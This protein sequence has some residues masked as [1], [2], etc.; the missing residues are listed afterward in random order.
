MAIMMQLTADMLPTRERTYLRYSAWRLA[1]ALTQILANLGASFYMDGESLSPGWNY[2]Y[3]AEAAK[4]RG[5]EILRNADFS[6]GFQNWELW[7][8]APAK[9]KAAL[10]ADVPPE[11]AGERSV[12]IDVTKPS[13]TAWHVAFWQVGLR[14]KAGVTYTWSAWMKASK[15]SSVTAAIEKNHPPF[16]TAG[17]FEQVNVSREW[18]LVRLDF[19]ATESDDQVRFSFQELARQATTFWFAGPSFSVKREEPEPR[20]MAEAPTFYSRD[21]IDDHARG[22]DPYRYYRW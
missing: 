9:A 14:L 3:T 5:P 4:P 12:R 11:L 6:K 16:G 22:D 21:F 15:P 18:K 10:S 19:T 8:A 2:A 17:L 7:T 13:D 20:E 1:R